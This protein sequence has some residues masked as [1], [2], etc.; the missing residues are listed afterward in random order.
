MDK[1][2]FFKRLF[3]GAAVTAIA[4]SVIKEAAT[5]AE[6][7]DMA[8]Y[9]TFARNMKNSLPFLKQTLPQLIAK[10]Y[11]RK[12][13]EMWHDIPKDLLSQKA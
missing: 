4:P 7:V 1:R 3:Q 13:N 6:N 2:T 12:E 5:A 8:G 9:A 11:Y 10:D